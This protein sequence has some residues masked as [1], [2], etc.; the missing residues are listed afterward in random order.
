MMNLKKSEQ[1]KENYY[2]NIVEDLKSSA[3]GQWY[4]KLKRMSSYHEVK[5]EQITV[6]EINHLPIQQQSEMIADNFSRISNE[7]EPIRE[8][9]INLDSCS[10]LNPAPILQPYQVYEYLQKLKKV[11]WLA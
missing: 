5:S 6:E 3:P 1:A 10:N 9:D 2:T 7:Y 11:Y 4:S 8:S